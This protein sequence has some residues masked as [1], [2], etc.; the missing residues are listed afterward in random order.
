MMGC[1]P[2]EEMTCASPL[3]RVPWLCPTVTP[4][5]NSQGGVSNALACALL[6]VGFLGVDNILGASY[7]AHSVP[8]HPSHDP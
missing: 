6:P 2:L 1:S 3:P 5:P 7:K 8:S 4:V